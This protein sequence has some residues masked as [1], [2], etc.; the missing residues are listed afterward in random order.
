VPLIGI[1]GLSR[2]VSR[3]IEEVEHTGEPLIVTRH[4]RPVVAIVPV[5]ADGLED[6]VLAHVPEFTLG[7]RAA[8]AELER[9]ETMPLSKVLDED[10]DGNEDAK[11]SRR[12]PTSR[13]AAART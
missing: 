4:G 13:R 11:T 2:R 12:R 6:F 7:M 1:R 10:A 8:D 9:G 5:D 3:Y